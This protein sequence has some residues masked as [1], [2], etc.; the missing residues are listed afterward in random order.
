LKKKRTFYPYLIFII[1]FCYFINFFNNKILSGHLITNY[2]LKEGE[3]FLTHYTLNYL[4]YKL[5]LADNNLIPKLGIDKKGNSF[6]AYKSNKFS[7]K[8]SL[9][10]IEDII[11]NPPTFENER[12]FLKNI[13]YL[14]HELEINVIIINFKNNKIAGQWDYKNRIIKLNHNLIESGTKIFTTVLNHEVIH[15]A[16]SCM[17]GGISSRPKKI[18]LK[19]NID[20]EKDFLLSSEIYRNKSKKIILF[21]KEAYSYQ[22]NLNLGLQLIKKYCL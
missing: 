2:S 19:L 18:G 6:Y 10:E 13:I 21:E 20:R 9:T 11:N 16:Q 7:K 17:N 3:F 4:N 14:L 5:K 12:S 22:D 8:L 15:I 1:N